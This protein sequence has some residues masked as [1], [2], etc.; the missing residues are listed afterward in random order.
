MQL[1]VSEPLES[2]SLIPILGVERRETQ[3]DVPAEVKNL[4]V[5]NEGI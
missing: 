5:L 4:R 3:L 2:F 1:F